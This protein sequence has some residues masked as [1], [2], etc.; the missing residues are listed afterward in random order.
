MDGFCRVL[1]ISQSEAL[2]LIGRSVALATKARTWF[3]D[4]GISEV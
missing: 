2:D 3:L 1:S 4:Q